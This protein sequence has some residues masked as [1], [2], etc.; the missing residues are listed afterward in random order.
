MSSPSFDPAQEHSASDPHPPPSVMAF[1]GADATGATGIACDV[2]TMAAMGAHAL[3]VTTSFIMRD[4]AE[5]FSAHCLDAEWVNEQARAVLEDIALSGF[6]IGF[7]GGPENIGT[8][9]EILS[10]Y[11]DVPVVTYLNILPFSDE[12]ERNGYLDGLRQLILPQTQL[13]MGGQQLLQELLLPDWPHDKA[14]SPRDLAEAATAFGC[15]SLLLTGQ[16][17]RDQQVE[18]ILVGPGGQIT[19][20]AFDRIEASFLGA[21][22]T[23]SA[24]IAALLGCGADLP[25]SSHE[26]LAFLDQALDCGF[27]PG[28]GMVV[29]DRFFWAL[30]EEDEDSPFDADGADDADDAD[31][32]PDD[33]PPDPAPVKHQVH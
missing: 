29:P 13:L 3:P 9:A 4:T 2:A 11:H 24:A 25:S 5:V 12:D 16:R 15:E 6:K 1:N 31:D 33:L 7:L 26:A 28:M 23:L 17:A 18:N 27:R 21:G 8:V 10:D 14:P 20:E 19:S 30:P 32:G 22:E